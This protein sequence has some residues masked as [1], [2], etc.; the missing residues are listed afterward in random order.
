MKKAQKK[1]PV[2]K[3]APK[4]THGPAHKRPAPQAPGAKGPAAKGAGNKPHAAGGHAAK[5]RFVPDTI[6]QG[7]SS[8]EVRMLQIL[9]EKNGFE[10]GP[11]DGLF[12]PMTHGA[13]IA[14]EYG[15]P[16]VV[17]VEHATRLIQDGQTIRVHG[18]DGYVEILP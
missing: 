8:N 11:I 5:S 9:L 3:A 17:G 2:P 15:L 13:V 12:G 7:S 6:A 14:R 16:A 4:A 18:T 1:K 10:C